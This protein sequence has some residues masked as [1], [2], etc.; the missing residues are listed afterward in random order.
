MKIV[1]R[2]KH[3]TGGSKNTG[4]R[5]EEGGGSSIAG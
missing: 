4:T 3:S 5:K 1:I 2:K